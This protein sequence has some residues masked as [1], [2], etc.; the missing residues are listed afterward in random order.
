[1][2]ITP[3]PS[4]NFNIRAYDHIDMIILHYTGMPTAEMALKRMTEDVAP[5]VSAHYFIS[6]SGQIFG[7]VPEEKRA[8]HAGI[9]YWKGEKDINSRSIGIELENKGHEWGYEAFPDAQ[10][11]ALI[12]LIKDIKTRHII[13]TQ[14][15][16]AHSDVAPLRKKDPGEKFPWHRL[17]EENLIPH[18]KPQKIQAKGRLYPL[19]TPEL[20][21]EIIPILGDIGYRVDNL[22]LFSKHNRA[23]LNAFQR[24]FTGLNATR[25]ITRIM[26]HKVRR[27]YRT[28]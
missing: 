17:A 20:L 14:N 11:E 8:W 4:P 18:I 2:K 9:A 28:H 7:L 16:L 12:A 23:A 10:I 22:R 6:R 1:M 26:L 15:I 5:R 21:R 27:Y 19:P 3:Y 13:P 25:E 24:R